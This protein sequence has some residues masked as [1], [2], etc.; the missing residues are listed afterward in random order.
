MNGEKIL[1]NCLLIAVLSLIMLM[2][3][4]VALALPPEATQ[5]QPDPPKKDK[6]IIMILVDGLQSGD[7]DASKAPSL[8]GIGM[9]GVKAEKVS[10]MPP[11][12]SAARIYTILS[13]VDPDVHRFTG[14]DTTPKIDTLLTEM[15]SKGLT[16]AL[17][18]GTGSLV[19]IEG[20]ISNKNF[21]PFGNDEQLVG[22]ALDIIKEHKPFLTVIALSGLGR[23]TE[24]EIGSVKYG[25]AVLTADTNVGK[26]IRQLHTEGIYDDTL[27]I[28]AGTTGTPP[29]YIKGSEFIAGLKMAPVCLKDIAPT[30]AYLYGMDMPKEK[31]LI[32]WNAFKPSDTRPEKQLLEERVK[33]LSDAYTDAVDSAARLEAEKILVQQEKL[34]MA[35]DKQFIEG[36]IQAREEQINRLNNKISIIKFVGLGLMVLFFV[37]MYIEYKFLKK[38]YLFFT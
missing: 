22:S 3:P 6:R 4:G 14:S 32:M 8:N 35:K 12:N 26:M 18:D 23:L 30:L 25:S 2:L 38:R 31:G 20:K 13:G 34:L 19:N 37:A 33:D 16:T 28:I 24:A 17:I 7:L 11:D 9:S 10:A 36:E 21:G 1:T 27:L 29:L 15:E 5:V